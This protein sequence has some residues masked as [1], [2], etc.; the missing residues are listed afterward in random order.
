MRNDNNYRGATLYFHSPCFDG[1]VSCLLAWEFLEQAGWTFRQLVPVNYDQKGKW[2]DE[3][4]DRPIAVVDFPYHP[5]AAF[6]A[7]HHQSA[8]LTPH[9]ENLFRARNN[10]FP[11][12]ETH[13]GNYPILLYDSHADS[14]S[15]L[16]WKRLAR[17]SAQRP[18]YAELVDWAARIDSARYISVEEAI[19]GSHPAL[20][21]SASLAVSEADYPEKLVRWLRGH[22]VREVVAMQEPQ[23]N[24]SKA[25][26]LIKAGLDRFSQS[27]R[28]TDDQIV[29][30]DVDCEGV[31]VNRYAP[32]Y[33]SYCREARYS[34][35]ITRGT[36]VV[37]RAMRNPWREFQSVPLGRIFAGIGGG[38]HERVGSYIVPVER[39]GEA[40]QIVE[41][42]VDAIR[43]YERVGR[44][45]VKPAQVPNR[46]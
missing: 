46:V 13:T 18:H 45:D 11:L 7:D 15:T 42:V 43:T 4:F 9:A 3:E 20:Q 17:F 8:F 35:G 29:L 5:Y 27:A 41:Q 1:I 24:F 38:G 10:D 19:F 23:R 16:L 44:I 36:E 33:Q 28:M 6:W 34:V 21:I 2:L 39:K 30:F 14:C 22:S 25:H 40:K 12:R 32:F 37:I 26:S 31:L